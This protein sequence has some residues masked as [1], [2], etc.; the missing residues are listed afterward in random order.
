MSSERF[1]TKAYR[2]LP[3]DEKEDFYRTVFMNMDTE[4]GAKLRQEYYAG[5]SG[6]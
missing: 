2:N 5:L 4:T 6:H 3:E 1:F